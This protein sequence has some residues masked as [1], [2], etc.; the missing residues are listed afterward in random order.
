MEPYRIVYAAADKFPRKTNSNSIR[1]SQLDGFWRKFIAAANPK[2]GANPPKTP[3]RD[4]TRDSSTRSM[5]SA[6]HLPVNRRC[7]PSL[8]RRDAN[9]GWG[10]TW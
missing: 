6:V 8:H 7:V 5:L 3:K 1:T 10:T 2:L 4:H 9:I